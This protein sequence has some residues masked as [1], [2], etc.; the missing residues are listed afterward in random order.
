MSFL[1]F[2][3]TFALALLPTAERLA[4]IENTTR[5]M[6][7][8][9]KCLSLLHKSCY[10]VLSEHCLSLQLC[11]LRLTQK[12]DSLKLIVVILFF[13]LNAVISQLEYSI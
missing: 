6:V 8:S 12:S 1:N 4:M 5:I 2:H 9:K 11:H 13:N 7:S 3:Y 10:G